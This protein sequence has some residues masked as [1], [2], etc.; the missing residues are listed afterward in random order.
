MEETLLHEVFGVSE[1]YWCTGTE[2]KGSGDVF[3]AVEPLDKLYVCP[4]CRSRDVIHKGK[5][6]RRVQTLSIWW[7]GCHGASA[8]AASTS[9]RL[10]PLLPGLCALHR[11]AEPFCL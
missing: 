11:N 5:R 1:S 8:I 9:L 4:K 7:L 10:P 2:V 6:T 3:V